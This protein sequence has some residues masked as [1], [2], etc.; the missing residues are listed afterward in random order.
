M[1]QK[2]KQRTNIY[3]LNL[4]NFTDR[5]TSFSCKSLKINSQQNIVSLNLSG[6]FETFATVNFGMNDAFKCGLYVLF[7]FL[8]QEA[9]R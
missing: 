3:I 1:P 2:I 4:L 7:Y 8:N 5:Y 9:T 6:H